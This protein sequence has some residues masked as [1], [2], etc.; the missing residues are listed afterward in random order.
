LGFWYVTGSWIKTI[1]F[2]LTIGFQIERNGAGF[3]DCG[4]NCG[5]VT[6]L[7]YHPFNRVRTSSDVSDG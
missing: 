6:H 1:A 7:A 3:A 2:A 5:E 4:S